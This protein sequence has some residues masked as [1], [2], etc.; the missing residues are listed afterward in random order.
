MNTSAKPSD[1]LRPHRTLEKNGV[2]AL[3]WLD[4]N[5]AGVKFTIANVTFTTDKDGVPILSTEYT[6]HEDG[7]QFE[8]KDRE[9]FEEELTEFALGLIIFGKIKDNYEIR[10]NNPEQ[11]SA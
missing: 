3:E 8:E 9:S 6:I 10:T 2:P 1:I 4:G 11:S 7:A 5:F